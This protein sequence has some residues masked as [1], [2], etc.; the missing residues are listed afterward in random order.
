M[1]EVLSIAAWNAPGPL[2]VRAVAIPLICGNT[3]IL[4]SSEV[5]PM[6]IS[7]IV[8]A[9]HEVVLILVV[10]FANAANIKLRQGY[11]KALSTIST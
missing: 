10:V 11:R 5:S 9:L 4:K 8:E 6:T 7:I 2:T 3:V 1:L